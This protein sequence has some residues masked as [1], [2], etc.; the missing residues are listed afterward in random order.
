M[1]TKDEINN[2]NAG[3]Y[4]FYW[5]SG[6]NSIVAVGV[7]REGDR[8]LAPLNWV[9]PSDNNCINDGDVISYVKLIDKNGQEP[10]NFDRAQVL[11]DRS[12]DLILK[13][14]E[15]SLSHKRK[16]RKSMINTVLLYSILGLLLIA[17]LTFLAL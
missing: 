4:R 1:I 2:L 17:S 6:G 9:A 10:D 11:L 3:I 15:E 13:L 14:Q 12:Q 7:N 8:W 5:H 16:T